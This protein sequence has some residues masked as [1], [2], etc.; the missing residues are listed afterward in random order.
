MKNNKKVRLYVNGVRKRDIYPF[1]SKYTLFMY[2]AK[3]FLI[4][5]FVV[6]FI[7]LVVYIT[8]MI[9]AEQNPHTITIEK[10]VEVYVEKIPAILY[11]IADCESGKR[12]TN[13][14]AIKGSASHYDS[15]GQVLVRGNSEKNRAS[16]DIGKYQINSYYWGKKATELHLNLF[17]EKDNE[18]MALYIFNNATGSDAWSASR[19]CWSK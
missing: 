15:N 14:K 8:A 9:Y 11:A 17:N 12:N 10:P 7:A 5:L 16:V 18:Q 19:G 2:R 1:M 13:G 6:G 4:R 3:K